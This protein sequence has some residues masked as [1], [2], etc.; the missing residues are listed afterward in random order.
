MSLAILV[1][2]NQTPNTAIQGT[3]SKLASLASLGA[4]DRRRWASKKHMKSLFCTLSLAIGASTV[5]DQS[6][7][8]EQ[9]WSYLASYDARPGSIRVNLALRKV[10][11]VADYS[12][13]VVTGTTYSSSQRQG[14]PE[15]S[16]LNRLNGLQEEVVAAISKQSPNIYAG[17]FTHNFE[18]L[19]YVY[20]K[21]PSGISEVLS[22]LYRQGCPGCK[23]YTNIKQDQRWSTYSDFLFP[24]QATREHY[25]LQLN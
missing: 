2:R 13:L 18:Q 5:P 9:W 21:D 11:P 23:T 7:A 4:P 24:N 3:A 14:L 1:M 12:F 15:L 25:G 22:A 8:S 17:T 16:D 20:V 6:L 10:A 19:H